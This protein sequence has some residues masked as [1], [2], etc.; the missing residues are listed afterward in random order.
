MCDGHKCGNGDNPCYLIDGEDA[1]AKG[2]LEYDTRK[3]FCIGCN[4]IIAEILKEETPMT[5]D[6][7]TVAMKWREDD[8]RDNT[9]DTKGGYSPELT[10]AL[11]LLERWKEQL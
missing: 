10:R 8:L 2:F 5:L 6:W 7:M 9:E 1:L 4:R 3:P 11:N